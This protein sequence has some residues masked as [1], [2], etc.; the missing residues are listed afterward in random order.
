MWIPP[1]P[2]LTLVAKNL[3][4]VPVVALS[5]SGNLVTAKTN[6]V[7]A[8]SAGYEVVVAGLTGSLAGYNGRWTL[9]SA[10]GYTF[11][12]NATTTD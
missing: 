11:T 8:F 12:Y 9:L 3:N 2:N 6:G 4:Y 7:H 1:A 10:S 5:Q